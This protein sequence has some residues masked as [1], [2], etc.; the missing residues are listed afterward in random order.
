MS[1]AVVVQDQTDKLSIRHLNPD[2]KEEITVSS[3]TVDIKQG[4]STIV[5]AAAVIDTST[6]KPGYSRTWDTATFPLGRYY[7]EWSLSDGSTTRV[8]FQ[9]FEVVKKPF[10]CPVGVSDFMGKYPYLSAQ[11][12]SGTTAD[13]FLNDAWDEITDRL[14]TRLRCYPGNV[15]YVETL[16]RCIEFWTVADMYQA[17]SRGEDTQDSDQAKV[18][19]QKA[20]D[21]LQTALGFMFVDEDDDNDIADSE[22]NTFSSG[23]LIR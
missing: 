19:R 23:E 5:S 18:Y 4:S 17:L 16:D 3:G 12:P 21:A 22:A 9:W 13:D 14:Y 1:I 11:Y 15:P 6:S 20:E 7:A 8:D 2:T 10:R